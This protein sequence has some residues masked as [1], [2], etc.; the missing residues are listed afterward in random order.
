MWQERKTGS[1]VMDDT[2]RNRNHRWICRIALLGLAIAPCEASEVPFED[3][4]PVIAAEVSP[5][6]TALADLDGDG[7][8]DLAAALGDRLAWYENLGGE[9]S[10]WPE[11]DLTSDT[12]YGAYN[13]AAE[14]LDGNG[15]TDLFV[16]DDGSSKAYWYRNDGGSPPAFTRVLAI[17]LIAPGLVHPGLVDLAVA[18]I[19]ADGDPDLVVAQGSVE[20]ALWIEVSKAATPGELSFTRHPLSP[21]TES[22]LGVI[23]GDV[24]ADG[25]VD[26]AVILF[27]Q[28]TLKIYEH[29]GGDGIPDWTEHSIPLTHANLWNAE[30]GDLDRDGDLDLI[31]LEVPLWRYVMSYENPGSLDGTWSSTEITRHPDAPEARIRACD[32]DLDG[33]SDLVTASENRLVWYDNDGGPPPGWQQRAIPGSYGATEVLVDDLDRDGDPDLLSSDSLH[34]QIEMI[35]NRTIHGDAAYAR[36]ADFDSSLPGAADLGAADLDGDLDMD[37]YGADPVSGAVRWWENEPSAPSGWIA[38]DIATDDAG[39]ARC[40]AGDIDR[41]NTTDIACTLR[42]SGEIVWYMNEFIADDWLRVDIV[43]SLTGLEGIDLVDINADGF[44][45]VIFATNVIHGIYLGNAEL[46][47][48]EAMIGPSF[49]PRPWIDHADM[50]GDGDLDVVAG[51]TYTIDWFVNAGDYAA[52]G[53]DMRSVSV[54]HEQFAVGDLDRDGDEDLV[55]YDAATERLT[56][57][58]RE[59]GGTPE[60][61]LHDLGPAP[62]NQEIVIVDLDADGDPDIVSASGAAGPLTAWLS[63]GQPSPTWTPA[64]LHPTATGSDAIAVADLDGDRD[65]DLATITAGGNLSVF[66]HLGGQF[67]LSTTTTGLGSVEPTERFA[68]LTIALDHRGRGGDSGVEWA[69]MVLQLEKAEDDPLDA[70]EAHVLFDSIELFRDDG[71]GHFESSEDYLMGGFSLDLDES[72]NSLFPFTDGDLNVRVDPHESLLYHVVVDM[73]DVLTVDD[74]SSFRMTHMAT[75]ARARD[76]RFD[77][78]L[79]QSLPQDGSSPTFEV[80]APTSGAVEGLELGKAGGGELT[81]TWQASCSA[82]D[83]DYAVYEGTLG[84]YASHVPASTG[85][86]TGGTTDATVTPTVGNRYFLVVPHNSGVEGS[87]GVRGDGSAR[88]SGPAACAPRSH[89][90]CE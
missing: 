53:W 78:D 73:A 66:E 20:A 11:R 38:H 55:L 69:E 19:D 88:Y 89:A 77:L 75:M 39:P 71:S 61:T 14:D 40:D 52:P 28:S 74:P 85:C 18:D 24:D 41:N 22:A 6:G 2:R 83:D 27:N 16:L 56:L 3:A 9:P 29:P 8:L 68:A 36:I 82:A 37:L 49:G 57:M 44:L 25:D 12:V 62:L 58:E 86:T 26:V 34:Q 65:P 35:E 79:R 1:S 10:S 23:P 46:G 80:L 5:G 70:A 87:H 21:S 63:D 42:D 67:G 90:G 31:T 72:G 81:L 51:G 4:A 13:L 32:I 64:V 15:R 54:A 7:D 60:T 17:D 45:D 47:W 50:D 76:A 43:D 30:L 59:P 48:T 84:D 33:D